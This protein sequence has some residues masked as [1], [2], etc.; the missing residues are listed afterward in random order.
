MFGN[1][2]FPGS[3]HSQPD[4]H[5]GVA[6]EVLADIRHAAAHMPG[7]GGIKAVR[8][9]RFDERLEAEVIIAVDGA[10]TIAAGHEIA[11]AVR[12]ALLQQ[13]GLAE[14][15]VHVEPL[16]AAGG[17]PHSHDGHRH[18]PGIYDGHQ[19]DESGRPYYGPADGKYRQTPD[20][21]HSH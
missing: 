4:G 14:V 7:V 3:E 12:R 8:A 16:E 15:T 11:L 9:R 21:G 20:I 18:A 5:D 19:H 2:S 13:H 1:S 17:A 6:P 10:L